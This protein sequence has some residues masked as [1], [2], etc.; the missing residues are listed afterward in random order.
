MIGL[1]FGNFQSVT[2]EPFSF[3][4]ALQ[5]DG[6]NDFLGIG[7]GSDYTFQDALNNYADIPFTF[8]TW[9]KVGSYS[10]NCRLFNKYNNNINADRRIQSLITATGTTFVMANQRAG[11]DAFTGFRF[12]NIAPAIGEWAYVLLAYGGGGSY[13]DMCIGVASASLGVLWADGSTTTIGTATGDIAVSIKNNYNTNMTSGAPYNDSEILRLG[14]ANGTSPQYMTGVLDESSIWTNKKLTS[15][16]FTALWNGGDFLDISSN[17][18]DYVSSSFLTDWFRMEA[19]V[20]TQI[21]NSSTGSNADLV[22][23]IGNPIIPH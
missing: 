14:S 10:T 1:G 21:E 22:N 18:G 20:S 15:A 23:F 3:G 11:S 4:N 5:F 13:T 17:S 8:G 7:G 19:V 9:V 2:Q 12:V 6:V 16:E